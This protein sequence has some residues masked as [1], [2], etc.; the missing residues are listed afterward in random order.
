MIVFSQVFDLKFSIS[1]FINSK[2]VFNF[3]CISLLRKK[4]FQ[5]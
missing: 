4:N 5:L 2:F 1:M 3:K